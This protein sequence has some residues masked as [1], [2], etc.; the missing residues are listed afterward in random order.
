M[1]LRT[2]QEAL[3]AAREMYE[4]ERRVDQ[5]LI[6]AMERGPEAK[7]ED[8]VDQ[9]VPRAVT[10]IYE[11][12]MLQRFTPKELVKLIRQAERLFTPEYHAAR[13][14]MLRTLL[15]LRINREGE[16]EVK[17]DRLDRAFAPVLDQ[18]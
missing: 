9:L 10:P 14:G 5:V 6:D 4:L 2:K 8:D 18:N 15:M 7:N 12:L 1:K 16:E 11:E 3:A 13:L 17:E